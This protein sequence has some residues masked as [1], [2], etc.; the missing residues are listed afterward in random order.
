LWKSSPSEQALQHNAC[1]TGGSF[2]AKQICS[3][4]ASHWLA[5]A[6]GGYV[7][8]NKRP[9]FLKR[10]KEQKRQAR[11]IEKREARRDRKAVKA[12]EGELPEFPELPV[13]EAQGDE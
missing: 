8:G 6:R 12:T 5:R 9:S 10:Q 4:H 2:Q 13:E 3:A 11:A 1:S 7:A